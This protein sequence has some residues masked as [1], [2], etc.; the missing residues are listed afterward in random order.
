MADS[1]TGPIDDLKRFRE[2]LVEKRR[3]KVKLGVHGREATE[4]SA[5]NRRV[6][7]INDHADIAAIQS[8]IE[9]IDRAIKDE[10]SMMP[11]HYE[12]LS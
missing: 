1:N 6:P 2:M 10:E 4:R 11:S 7:H 9:A 8:S 5:A 3:E 12:A